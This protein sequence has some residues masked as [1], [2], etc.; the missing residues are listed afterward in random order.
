MYAKYLAKKG[1]Y[2]IYLSLEIKGENID[3]NVHPTKKQVHFLNQV[4][5]VD[6]LIQ[7]MEK[8][9][10]SANESRTFYVQVCICLIRQL[11]LLNCLHPK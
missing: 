8:C 11:S 2:F 9:L 4:K 3:V 5:I 6:S 7:T 1:H 10:T